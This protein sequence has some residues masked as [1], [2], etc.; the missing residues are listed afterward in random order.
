MRQQPTLEVCYQAVAGKPALR[1]AAAEELNTRRSSCQA[2]MTMVMA[3]LGN[4]QARR[5][6]ALQFM[7]A[8]QR[9]TQTMWQQNMQTMQNAAP[10]PQPTTPSQTT[11]CSSQ[12]VGGQLQTICQ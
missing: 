9:S 5:A 2:E 12:V 6:A 3:R 7:Q 8:Q 4:D 10:K 11:V 1:A